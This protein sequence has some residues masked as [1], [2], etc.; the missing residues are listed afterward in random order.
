M[1]LSIADMHQAEQ[2]VVLKKS[3]I[4]D[5][6][7]IR[8]LPY[9]PQVWIARA[10]T[11]LALGYG[12]LASSDAYKAHLLCKAA[13][14][15]EIKAREPGD[16]SLTAKVFGTILS[17]LPQSENQS[18]EAHYQQIFSSIKRM[19]E[20]A[21]FL[22]AHGLLSVSAWYDARYVL[23]EAKK[24]FPKNGKF[25]V[26][27][28][29]LKEKITLLK[30]ILQVHGRD[31]KTVKEILH[32]G[33]LERVSYPWIVAKEL[34]RSVKAV[35]RLNAQFQAASTN[36]CILRSP[37]RGN[38]TR[39][40]VKEDD[41]GVY[42]ENGI[43]KGETI[44]ATRSIWTDCAPGDGDNHCLACCRILR[45]KDVIRLTSCTCVFCSDACRQEAIDTYHNV[46]CGREFSWLYEAC[47]GADK[48]FSD[49]IPLV[50]IKILGTAV[51]LDCEP[52]KVPCIESLK[53][54]NDSVVSSTFRLSSNVIAPIQILETLGVD[55]FTNLK[56]DSWALQTLIM[57]IEDN[58]MRKQTLGD[59]RYSIIDPLFSMFNHSCIPSASYR[60]EGG[61][62]AMT[63]KAVR[64]IKKGEEICI[65]YVDP[66]MPERER[67]DELWRRI[68]GLCGCPSCKRERLAE[69]IQLRVKKER[70][71]D[72]RRRSLEH[73][74]RILSERA[75]KEGERLVRKLR[76]LERASGGMRVSEWI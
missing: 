5:Y 1:Y 29:N 9:H 15:E 26:L 39:E 76:D 16:G 61:G 2:T 72:E 54:N 4:Q 34:R 24:A 40:G 49:M 51:H 47:K 42:A 70:E 57:R 21:Y 68:G 64:D 13:T 55:I 3:L 45:N 28:M 48:T 23:Q 75:A 58:R 74:R 60:Y 32:R 62:T 20:N 18:L 50:M 11:F 27:L 43:P 33:Q 25:R 36:A 52:L 46:I 35:R 37:L 65:S 63:V 17:K 71:A 8:L 53:P 14:V 66:W 12:E 38:P 73:R 10:A 44:L 41:F 22:M 19:H 30:E 56:F 7:M 6:R 67:R 69:E 59:L 31:E